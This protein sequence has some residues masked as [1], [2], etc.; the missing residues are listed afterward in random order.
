MDIKETRQLPDGELENV[1]GGTPKY[2]KTIGLI[3][4]SIF[5]ESVR[6][7]KLLAV[8][9][10]STCD[11]FIKAQMFQSKNLPNLCRYCKFFQNDSCTRK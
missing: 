5:G 3:P 7:Q 9:P 8:T 11:K 4:P 2:T 1:Q 10:T 6:A